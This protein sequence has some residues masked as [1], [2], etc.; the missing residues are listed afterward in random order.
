M[1]S[2]TLYYREPLRAGLWIRQCT[3]NGGNLKVGKDK[4]L[5]Q[6][7]AQFGLELLLLS[8]GFTHNPDSLLRL[9]EMSCQCCD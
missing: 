3:F 9:L 7:V 2:Q 6:P 8:L 4:Y 5:R 1:T